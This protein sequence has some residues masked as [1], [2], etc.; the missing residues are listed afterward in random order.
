VDGQQRL[1]TLMLVLRGV[2]DAL[3]EADADSRQI[4]R[5]RKLIR[6]DEEVVSGD[7]L[8]RSGRGPPTAPHISR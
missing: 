7:A 8:V 3:Q 2:L 6:N 5:V 4:A 1:T